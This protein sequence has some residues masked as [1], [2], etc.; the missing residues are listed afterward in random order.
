M[1][2]HAG[3]LIL[4]WGGIGFFYEDTIGAIQCF[5]VAGII[6]ILALIGLFTVIGFIIKAVKRKKETPEEKW[7]RTGR[8][9]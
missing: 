7:M 6:G 5:V 4:T 1:K 3:D 8:M 2:F 9:S